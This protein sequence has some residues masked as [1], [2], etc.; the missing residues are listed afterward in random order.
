MLKQSK[1]NQNEGSENKL[2][3]NRLNKYD[4]CIGDKLEFYPYNGSEKYIVTNVIKTGNYSVSFT[5]QNMKTLQ[6]IYSYPSS[7]CYGALVMKGG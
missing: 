2:R 4:V 6:T 1:T 7:A 3:L 5:L